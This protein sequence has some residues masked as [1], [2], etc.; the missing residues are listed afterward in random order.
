MGKLW[1]VAGRQV[2]GGDGKERLGAYVVL[3]AG[4]MSRIFAVRGTTSS[5]E[6][7]ELPSATTIDMK[8][9]E[10]EL[11]KDL[12]LEAGVSGAQAAPATRP[13]EAWVCGAVRTHLKKAENLDI[14]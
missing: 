7:T 3:S 6:V 14:E 4:R 8:R 11:E 10:S 1:M 13:S 12:R 9:F 2:N 5:A